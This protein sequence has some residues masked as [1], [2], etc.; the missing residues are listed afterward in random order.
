MLSS[1]ELV[2]WDTCIYFAWLRDEQRPNH[3]IDGVYE[4]A[5]KINER[6]QRLICSTIVTAQI[7]KTKM[8]Q[9]SMTIFEKFLKR[10]SVQYV[11]FEHRA[12]DL[13]SEIM[14]YYNVRNKAQGKKMD[15]S[16]AQHLA[17][18][19]LYQVDAFYTFDKGEKGGIDLLSLSGNVAG[20]SLM[21]CKPP[22]PPQIRMDFR[23]I[24]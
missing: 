21:I 19:I 6:K 9:A 3:E 4:S 17:I 5:K 23:V 20:H 8:G 24:G 2:Y 16:D 11:D 7:Y 10:R 14:E 12:A 22:L 1:I 13:T 15:F 18:S